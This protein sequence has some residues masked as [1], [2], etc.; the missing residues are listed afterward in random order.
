[1]GG[2]H[3]D[4]AHD[5][6]HDAAHYEGYPKGVWSPT[7][8]WWS[9]HKY[10]RRNTALALAGIFLVCIPIAM[11]SARLE[12]RPIPPRRPIPSQWW[13]KNFG[14]PTDAE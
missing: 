7:G 5:V 1:M 11:T 6:A 14:K 12:Q 3:R 10:W 13:C 9:D 2:G 4:V 8:G